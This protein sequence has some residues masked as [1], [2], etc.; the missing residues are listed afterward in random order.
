MGEDKHVEDQ[1]GEE[2]K[3]ERTVRYHQHGTLSKV[4]NKKEETWI[5]ETPGDHLEFQG[6][7]LITVLD[8]LSKEGYELVC[9]C[10]SDDEYILRTKIEIKETEEYWDTEDLYIE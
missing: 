7:D 1:L 8:D 4:H 9:S 5:F 6:G 2:N 10:G 3:K